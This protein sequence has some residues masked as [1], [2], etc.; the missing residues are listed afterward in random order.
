MGLSF[1]T[2][3]S[4]LVAFAV[5]LPLAALGWAEW[6][7]GRVRALLGVAAPRGRSRAAVPLAI[8]AVAVLAGAAAM[9]PVLDRT[10]ARS[11]RTDAEV[12]VVLDSS[13]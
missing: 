4:G 13:R 11:E 3:M 10:R 2:P 9:Q 6:R 12:V 1:L 5:V 8:T 7:R